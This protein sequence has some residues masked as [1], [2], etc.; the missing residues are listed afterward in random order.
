MPNSTSGHIKLD[1]ITPADVKSLRGYTKVETQGVIF[2]LKFNHQDGVYV[3][4]SADGDVYESPKLSDI[5]KELKSD[6]SPMVSSIVIV[7]GEVVGQ[8]M[9]Q[10][11]WF[12]FRPA[13]SK[14]DLDTKKLG[15][16]QE[17]LESLNIPGA[18]LSN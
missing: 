5:K 15:H 6:A 12:F 13:K 8:I 18:E 2:D 9:N 14:G 3:A 17:V 11:N 4:R 7:A 10:Q 16:P 1:E